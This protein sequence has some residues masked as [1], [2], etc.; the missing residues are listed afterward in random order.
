[1]PVEQRSESRPDG[2]ELGAA[3]EAHNSQS[4][5]GD[6]G[7]AF[8][9]QTATEAQQVIKAHR[10]RR[11]RIWV[12]LGIVVAVALGLF[13]VH[14][15][16]GDKGAA[17][18]GSAGA[19]GAAGAH[20]GGGRG[21]NGPAAITTAETRTG[22]INVYVDA[23]GTVTP[24]NTISVYS[25]VTG[26]VMAVNYR[27]GQMVR[28]G[29]SLIEIDPRPYQATLA[30]AQGT[31]QH[32]QGVLAEAQIDL[33]RYQ[34][35]FARNAIAKQQ[36]DDQ[37]QTVLQDQGTVAQDQASVNY[38][39]VQLSYCHIIAPITGR[40]GLRLVD[41]G[42]TVFSGT[43]STLVVITQLQP[44]TVVFNVSEDSLPE[45]QAQLKGRTVLSVDAYDRGDDKKIETGKLTSLDNEVDTTTGTVKF[46]A[47][48]DNR[49]NEFYPNQFVNA[50]LL[51]KT[52]H[53]ATLV[54]TAAV[55]R[56]GTQA[57]VYV[58]GKN[59]KN[60]DIVNARNISTE[61]NNDQVTAI[62]G[63]G[64]G[65]TVATSGFDRLEDG[66]EVS[67]PDQSGGAHKPSKP[68]PAVP[69]GSKP[70]TGSPATDTGTNSSNGSGSGAGTNGSSSG[71]K[72]P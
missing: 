38:D 3:F 20:G 42:N 14:Q 72:A 32:D 35:A 67:L 15:F 44:I 62:T 68:L 23:L 52:L 71:S 61:T 48:F 30:Q 55:Q 19:P 34:D 70:P 51:V 56:N 5:G 7:E 49:N 63:I 50:H 11:S 21:Q 10:S 60:R 53:N 39:E 16:S 29:Q 33:K 45:V 37:E 13:L 12:I 24:L 40:V 2:H 4:Y 22:D 8:A 57:F 46:R 26:R 9:Q 36:L 43:G 27:E 18:G 66:A 64:P 31:L 6:V 47:T 69:G 58:L 65:V 59:K 17:A 25:Q 28:K 41:V 54:S 1:M